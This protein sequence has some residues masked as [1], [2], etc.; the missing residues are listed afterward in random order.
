M[1][2]PSEALVITPQPS[3]SPVV[4]TD[5]LEPNTLGVQTKATD[6]HVNGPLPD[7]E[8][9]PG[10]V[11]PVT[12]E[13]ICTSGY[14]KSVRDVSAKTKEK[15]FEEYGIFEHDSGEYEVDH[16]ISLEL[17]GS[18]DISNLWPESANPK[19]GFKEKDKVE[20][21]LHREVCNG[22]M[23]LIE[24]QQGIATNWM[25]YYTFAAGF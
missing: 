9:T 16:L 11:L 15:V 23:N 8:C 14:T 19:P 20:N 2:L 3:S 6:C 5:I 21:F 17:G 10:A 12:V 22:N 24:A 4:P 1:Q 7:V 13:Q 25:K 18:N